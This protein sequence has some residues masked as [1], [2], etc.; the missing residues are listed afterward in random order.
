MQNSL[1]LKSDQLP[2]NLEPA[3]KEFCSGLVSDIEKTHDF[4]RQQ[5]AFIKQRNQLAL[6]MLRPDIVA[7]ATLRDL[8]DEPEVIVDPKMET[9][10][11]E[12]E[13]DTKEKKQRS[14]KKKAIPLSAFETAE[15][16]EPFDVA[17]T[18]AGPE[19]AVE[20]KI[21]LGHFKKLS[22]DDQKLLQLRFV[23]DMA[24]KDI[25]EIFKERENTIAVRISRALSRL[26]DELQ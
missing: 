14:K 6:R 4:Y 17:S 12:D 19:A 7:E 8:F 2:D 21:A 10:I 13:A 18:D 1:N 5:I 25:A 26:R 15:S 20:Y 22:D 9:K 11:E 3:A 16:D 23:E 24:V